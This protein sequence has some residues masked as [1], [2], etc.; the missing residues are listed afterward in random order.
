MLER[1][2]KLYEEAK[3]EC[4]AT[5]IPFK[6]NVPI[7]VSKR[8]TRSLGR[9]YY[10][11]IDGYK[12]KISAQ[13]KPLSDKELKQ[14]IV[15]EILHT[16]KGCMNHGSKW[17]SYAKKMNHTYGYD[18]SRLASEEVCNQLKDVRQE[19]GKYVIECQVCKAIIPR[20][21]MSNLVKH[22]EWYACQCGGNLKR[23]K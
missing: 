5:N 21:K 11:Y 23:I 17:Q 13:I 6:E 20:T 8:M 10:N 19:E 15:H 18:I 14:V 3:K 4:R 16:C 2:K 22:P 9:C 12:I 1:V 7:E